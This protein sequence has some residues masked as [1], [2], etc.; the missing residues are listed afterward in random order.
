LYI[1]AIAKRP[2]RTIDTPEKIHQTIRD[3]IQD[4]KQKFILPQ[5]RPGMIV[6]DISTVNPLINETGTVPLLKLKEELLQGTIEEFTY[7]VYEDKEMFERPENSGNVFAYLV[8]EF[9][10]VNKTNYGVIACMLTLITQIFNQNGKIAF[11]KLHQLIVDHNY[12]E[13]AVR[14]I[15]KHVYLV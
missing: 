13:L 2:I 5:Y 1:E 14:E 11:P 15:A 12:K 10:N 4:K 8:E 6:G 3:I 9:M 7:P